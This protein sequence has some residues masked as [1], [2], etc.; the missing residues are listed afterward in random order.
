MQDLNT[1]NKVWLAN[2]KVCFVTNSI[3]MPS[4]LFI[5][6]LKT[7]IEYIPIQN[8]WMIP[9]IKDNAPFY[10]LNAFVYMLDYMLQANRFDYV[11]YID[12]DCFI[13]DFNGLIDEFKEFVK[14]EYCLAG[15]PDGGVMCHRNHSKMMINTFLSFWNI[16][17]LREKNITYNDIAEYV[18]G[19]IREHPKSMFKHFINIME[20]N[21]PDLLKYMRSESDATIN[22]VKRFRNLNFGRNVECPYCETV[23][24]DPTNTI[25]RYQTPYTYDDESAIDNFEPY[26][27]LEQALIY[28]TNTPIYYLFTTD[29]YGKKYIEEKKE[30][31]LSGLTSAVYKCTNPQGD[32]KLIAVH[33]W[34]SR[35]YTKWPTVPMQLEH[36]KRI[37]TIIR[38]FS[39]V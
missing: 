31:D 12:E 29:L 37:N 13:T 32:F 33:T 9:G 34:Y 21:R 25:E 23:K 6:S 1:K 8:F 2:N 15:S 20:E 17:L 5:A 26:Y 30:F 11:I 10:G 4:S 36:T 19:C 22:A 39:S 7:Y 3:G 18:N 24:D 35:A 38:E 27:V 14:G 28:L 16:K